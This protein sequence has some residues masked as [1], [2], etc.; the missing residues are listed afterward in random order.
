MSA[1]ADEIVAAAQAGETLCG[2]NSHLVEDEC[3]RELVEF[4]ANGRHTYDFDHLVGRPTQA[5]LRVLPADP[6]ASARY[7]HEPAAPNGRRGCERCGVAYGPS[8]ERTAP[9]SWEDPFEGRDSSRH[10]VW[11]PAGSAIVEL[12][13]CKACKDYLDASFAPV[14]WR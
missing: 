6:E 8:A 3:I 12:V 14:E 2:G 10:T 1:L 5:H 9:D 13:L 11:V 4:A 7:A